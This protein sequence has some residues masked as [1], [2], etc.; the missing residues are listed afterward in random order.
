MRTPGTV[1][2][3]L[4]AIAVLGA[5]AG[6]RVT[7]PWFWVAAAMLL[8]GVWAFRVDRNPDNGPRGTRA[9]PSPPAEFIDDPPRPPT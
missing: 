2:F 4:L 6:P 1:A 3:V 7:T 5:A 9:A 8:V